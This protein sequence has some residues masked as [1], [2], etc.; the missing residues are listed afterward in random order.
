MVLGVCRIILRDPD[1]AE[2]AAQQAFLS[3]FRAMLD[4]SAPRDPAAWLGTIARNECR[5]RLRARERAP[6]ALTENAPPTPDAHSVVSGREDAET[7]LRALSNLSERQREALILRSLYGLS[8]REVAKAL[9]TSVAG[10]ETLLFRGRRRLS[11]VTRPQLAAAHA[12]LVLPLALKVELARL[13]PGFEAGAASGGGRAIGVAGG[14]LGIAVAGTAGG[15]GGPGIAGLLGAPVAARIVGVV[16]AVT[17]G[18]AAAPTLQSPTG[19]PPRSDAA[20]PWAGGGNV[21]AEDVGASAGR[22]IPGPRE[23]GSPPAGAPRDLDTP[24]PEGALRRATI[25][26]GGPGAGTPAIDQP[27]GTPA[28]APKPA[29]D[30][31]RSDEPKWDEE[32]RD[33]SH[34][35]HGDDDD[36]RSGRRD[37]DATDTGAD[38]SGADTRKNEGDGGDSSRGAETPDVPKVAEPNVDAPTVTAPDTD[39]TTTGETN[40][41]P[42]APPPP[43]AEAPTDTTPTTTNP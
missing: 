23:A 15:G 36:D 32:D 27:A 2:D 29:G 24:S 35:R 8:Y 12:L 40:M 7:V 37:G 41:A 39:E 11:E 18:V 17:I 3:A 30:N 4:G 1:E 34:R 20:L 9:G 42:P 31:R 16:T 6:L 26:G 28:T 5:T 13:V 33:A 22:V 10:V 14:A 21:A 25:T 19:E 38:E 43:P